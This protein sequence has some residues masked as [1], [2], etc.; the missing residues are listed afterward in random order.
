LFSHFQN[1]SHLTRNFLDRG[2]SQRREMKN[3]FDGYHSGVNDH[4]LS[5][6]CTQV[7]SFGRVL[8]FIFFKMK[9]CG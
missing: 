3:P 6:H 5:H 8:N 7:H 1:K 4:P 2:L 9:I